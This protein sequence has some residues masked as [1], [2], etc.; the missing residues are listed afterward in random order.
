LWGEDARGTVVSPRVR[1]AHVLGSWVH[2]GDLWICSDC[3]DAG[4]HS[5]DG[6]GELC[7][8]QDGDCCEAE[9]DADDLDGVH[10]YGF[11]P[12]PV[13]HGTGPAFYGVELELEAAN[14]DLSGIV[15]ALRSFD[16]SESLHY[17]KDDS[18]LCDGVELVTHPRSLES[19]QSWG[20]E[21]ARLLHAASAEGAAAWTRSR[22][23]LHVHMSRAG[24]DGAAHL[25]RL[26][27]LVAQNETGLK[28]FAG[29][30]SSY[31]SWDSLKSGGAVKKA[32]ESWR[33]GH[34]DAL[35]LS[36]TATVELRIFR[37]SLA[38]GRVLAA[39]ELCDALRVYT[40]DLRARDIAL[41]AAAWDRFSLWLLGQGETYRH[42]AHVL[43]GGR[44]RVSAD[45]AGS[46]VLGGV[47]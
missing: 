14:G 46:F 25:A 36:P 16:P 34:S 1:A 5:C 43:R 39:V 9:L 33:A 27:Y 10:S 15:G 29:R 12:S 38:A 18:S 20:S 41:G 35:N 47:G 30:S 17:C 32:R 21:L 13:F 7:R 19:W 22:C 28:A 44:F 11:K 6:C 45:L 31:A 40:R 23:G 8:D 42:A 37:P 2:G 4:W 24:F 3:I 26:A